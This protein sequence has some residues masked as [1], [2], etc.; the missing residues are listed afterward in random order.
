MSLDIGGLELTRGQVIAMIERQIDEMERYV[1]GEDH[2]TER[3]V[4]DYISRAYQLVL[5]YR[6]LT[7]Q[8]NSE[9]MNGKKRNRRGK[10]A[11]SKAQATPRI[12]LCLF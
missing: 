8:G 2:R 4:V 10:S 5:L 12:Q 9:E 7:L 11:P 1:L 3:D 6:C